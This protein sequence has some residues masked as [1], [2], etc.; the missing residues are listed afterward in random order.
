[1]VFKDCHADQ[2][3][4][5]ESAHVKAIIDRLPAGMDGMGTPRQPMAQTIDLALQRLEDLDILEGRK[6]ATR[7]L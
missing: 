5:S 6:C 3:P 1:M 4:P 2:Q 7:V